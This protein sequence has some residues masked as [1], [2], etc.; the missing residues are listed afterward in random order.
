MKKAIVDA[1][2]EHFHLQGILTP[3]PFYYIMET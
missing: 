1:I 2:P 3:L